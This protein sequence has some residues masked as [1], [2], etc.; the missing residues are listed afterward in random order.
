MANLSNPEPSQPRRKFFVW[1]GQII[2]G[3]SLAGIG[4]GLVDPKA[5]LA[6]PECTPCSGC[7]ILSCTYSG[8]CRAQ[9][10]NTPY[11][12]EY[13]AYVGC[14]P[15]GCTLAPPAYE[16]NSGCGC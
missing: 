5:V 13:Q 4:L 9:N 3:A 12:V 7:K 1:V 14:V 16:C 10:P 11:L 2:A 8:T 15:P 6:D